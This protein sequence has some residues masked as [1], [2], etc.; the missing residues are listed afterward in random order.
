MHQG[1]GSLEELNDLFCAWA[2][3]VANRRIHAET[4]ET[5]IARFEADGPHR[6]APPERMEEAFRWSAVRK[7]TK[8]ATVSLEGNAYAVDPALVGRRVELR[9]VPEKLAEIAVYFEGR[10]IGTATPFVVSRHVHR[11]V[12]QAVPPAVEESGI[13]FLQMVAKAYEEEAG[14]G[15]KPRFSELQLFPT[16]EI[17]EEAQS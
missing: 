4:G 17:N 5:P 6:Q 2:A 3:Q 12:P 10:P 14:T 13:D 11:A 9:Y 1:I 16:D 15:E 8:V 7:V